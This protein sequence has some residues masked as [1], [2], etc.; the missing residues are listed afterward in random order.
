MNTMNASDLSNRL[1]AID[2]LDDPRLQ[3]FLNLRERTLRGESL[4]IAEGALVVERL[5]CSDYSVESILTIPSRITDV[6]ISM[7]PESTPIYC[8]PERDIM[9]R[10]VGFD[11]HQGILAIGRRP[12]SFPK[13]EDAFARNYGAALQRR[14][15][16]VRFA[17]TRTRANRCWV[18]LPD[19]TK[20]DNLG[21]VFRCAAALDAEGVILGETCCDPFSRR[22]LRVSMGGVLQVPIFQAENLAKE[23]DS[24]KKRR[25]IVCVA[26]LLAPESLPLTEF[27]NDRFDEETGFVFLFGNEYYGL[28]Q[29]MINLCDHKVIIPMRN[30]VD[31]LNLGTS[32]GICLY[33]FNRWV[34]S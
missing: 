29:Q 23:L 27:F 2:S 21:L 14:V 24:A 1:I 33:E 5:L 19:A 6:L 3:P 10:I 18:V 15:E 20:P 11:F 4:F 12:N 34:R 25:P 13:V 26:T 17:S 30:D 32:V 8:V 22:A 31:S 7:T 9:N 28:D 16:D